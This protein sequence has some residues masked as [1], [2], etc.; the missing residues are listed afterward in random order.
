MKRVVGLIALSAILV[1]PLSSAAE[2]QIAASCRIKNLPPGRCGWC[3]V[4]TLARHLRLKKLHGIT[5]AHATRTTLEDLEG[6]IVEAG[7]HY[8]I[9]RPGDLDTTILSDAVKAG[10]G[11]AVGFRE[12]YP[13]AGGHIVTLVD[14]TDQTVRVIDPNDSDGRTRTISLDRFLYWW[15]GFA[16]V[17]E[18]QAAAE[19]AQGSN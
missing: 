13:G 9:Q 14:F 8:R 17:L 4:E 19:V 3:A 6:I 10:L 12:L 15:D 1:I 5:Q 11:A 7:I 18:R 16:L 2:V